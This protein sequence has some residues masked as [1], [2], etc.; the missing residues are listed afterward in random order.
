MILG[1]GILAPV[2][3]S[4]GSIDCAFSIY[5]PRGFLR[6]ASSGIACGDRRAERPAELITGDRVEELQRAGENILQRAR[7]GYAQYRAGRDQQKPGQPRLIV[8]RQL[9]LFDV[10]QRGADGQVVRPERSNGL[11]TCRRA[12][13]LDAAD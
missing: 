2:P 5:A 11:P 10:N 8:A 7:R 13:S 1:G 12:W 9:L 3:G 4:A 6:L